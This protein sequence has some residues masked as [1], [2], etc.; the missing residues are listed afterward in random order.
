VAGVTIRVVGAR[1]VGPMLHGTVEYEAE[2]RTW[3]HGPFTSRILDDDELEAELSR[4]GLRLDRWL[5]D[6]R[7][8]LAARPIAA[9]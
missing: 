3:R 7:S 6:A 5:D 2:G 4:V 9:S 8:W 1:R